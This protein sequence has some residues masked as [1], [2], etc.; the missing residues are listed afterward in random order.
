MDELIFHLQSP[1]EGTNTD[2][3]KEYLIECL[4]PALVIFVVV[5]LFMIFFRKKRWFYVF[6]GILLVVFIIWS[7]RDHILS[8]LTPIMW[9]QRIQ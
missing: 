5:I 1:L 7:L 9:I 2:M 6:D 8:L 4:A 3:V